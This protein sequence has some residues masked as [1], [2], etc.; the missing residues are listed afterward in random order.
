MRVLRL[1]RGY[2]A[3]PMMAA[4]MALSLPMGYA[5]AALV[6]TEQAIGQADAASSR[7]MV[8]TFLSRDDVRRQMIEMGVDAD[9]AAARVNGLSDAELAEVAMKI[10]DMPAGEG[11]GSVVVILLLVLLILLILD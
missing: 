3:W 9:E 7:A 6:T 1:F 11:A 10:E 5:N 2:I 4:I 8:G